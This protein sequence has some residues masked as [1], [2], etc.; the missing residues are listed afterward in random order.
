MDVYMYIILIFRV[1][2][3]LASDFKVD[4][5]ILLGSVGATDH[6]ETGVQ[7]SMYVENGRELNWRMFS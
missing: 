5:W 4:S 7:C 3:N 1:V 2:S 6:P